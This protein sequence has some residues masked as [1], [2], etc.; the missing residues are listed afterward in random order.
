ML[1][2]SL[3]RQPFFLF[4]NKPN[5][6]FEAMYFTFLPSYFFT[7]KGSFYLYKRSFYLFTFLLFYL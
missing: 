4:Y 7:L 1:I 2:K 6:I 3:W 5:L